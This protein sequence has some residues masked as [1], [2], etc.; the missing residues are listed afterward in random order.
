[1]KV[2]IITKKAAVNYLLVQGVRALLVCACNGLHMTFHPLLCPMFCRCNTFCV[3]GPTW[4]TTR[5]CSRMST[6]LSSCCPPASS[7]LRRCVFCTCTAMELASYADV[8]QRVQFSGHRERSYSTRCFFFLFNPS[9]CK[10][11]ALCN[12]TGPRNGS[13][14]IVMQ[15]STYDRFRFRKAACKLWL[16]KFGWYRPLNVNSHCLSRSVKCTCAVD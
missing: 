11:H 2:G 13:G 9:L 14:I 16:S 6:S 10:L 7:R 1:M 4:R 15:E 3:F 12:D 8:G 5:F